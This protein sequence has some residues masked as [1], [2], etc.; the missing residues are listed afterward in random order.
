MT[1]LV[2][3]PLRDV[4]SGA[5]IKTYEIWKLAHPIKDFGKIGGL[6]SVNSRPSLWRRW[7][8]FLTDG[9]RGRLVADA[10]G[11]SILPVQ[12]GVHCP[13]RRFVRMADVARVRDFQAVGPLRIDE[14]EGMAADVHV[15]D[16]LLDFRHVAG[17]A[18]AAR[19]AR[20]MV[21]MLFDRRGM[22]A[23]LRVR[24]VTGEAYAAGRLPQHGVI[25]RA[26]RIM[27]A[28]AG[29]AACIH[30]AGHEVVA[31]HPVLVRRAIR[32]MCEGRLAKLVILEL[33]E[34]VQA[35]AGVKSDR[36]IIVFSADRIL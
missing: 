8:G 17:D 14:V 35:E 28:E 34:V 18:L 2:L 22:R 32:K 4:R 13:R 30:Q 36:P 12:Q 10:P 7:L 25:I 11:G 9:L 26:V 16:R 27:A 15:C 21:G 24:P 31:L 6:R 23:I 19:A 20:S 29:D 1:A 5:Q 33:P 3:P